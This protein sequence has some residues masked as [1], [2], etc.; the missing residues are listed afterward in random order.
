MIP[1]LPLMRSGLSTPLSLSK[2]SIAT[3]VEVRSLP[4]LFFLVLVPSADQSLGFSHLNNG[5]PPTRITTLP[6]RIRVATNDAPAHVQSITL[7]LAAAA[8]YETDDTQ[9]FGYLLTKLA[10][11]VSRS[12]C[13]PEKQVAFQLTQ[14]LPSSLPPYLPCRLQSTLSRTPSDFALETQRNICSI[15][16]H[17][18]RDVTLY[19]AAFPSQNIAPVFSLLTDT[20]LHPL[21]TPPEVEEVLDIAA[22]ELKLFDEQ[23]DE[24]LLQR[25]QNV[26]FG[27]KGLGR[28][29]FPDAA[30]VDD[31][32]SGAYTSEH[33]RAY[34]KKWFRPERMVVAGTGMEHESLVEL[35]EKELGHLPFAG[36]L[37]EDGV[38]MSSSSSPSASSS[39]LSIP[40]AAPSTASSSSPPSSSSSSSST[41]GSWIS[42][43]TSSP[44]SSSS[45]TSSAS[46]SSSDL[47]ANN[48]SFATLS[49]SQLPPPPPKETD[50]ISLEPVPPIDSPRTVYTGGVSIEERNDL[51]MQHTHLFIGFEGF[52]ANDDDVVSASSPSRPICLSLFLPLPLSCLV[53]QIAHSG[54]SPTWGSVVPPCRPSD[55][56]RRRSFL[57]LGRTRQG[58]PLSVLHR[59]DVRLVRHR[60]R[61]I[62]SSSLP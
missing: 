14:P 42:S 6:N 62:A 3:F 17:E 23:H 2:R 39:P 60:S 30:K 47:P 57:L 48:K 26:G 56:P 22:W 25:L 10:M 1:R 50:Y 11:K 21:L 38:S 8:R 27:G 45:S 4:F 37:E 59:H 46:S 18:G 33:L 28:N 32:K 49:E 20:V 53:R 31:V 16:S 29:P 58:P 44:S 15:S 54:F 36:V 35:V 19:Q 34:R 9:G 12:P 41:F 61:R 52:G 13:Y 24:V 55:S 51:D 7:M 5:Q 43:L 40:S